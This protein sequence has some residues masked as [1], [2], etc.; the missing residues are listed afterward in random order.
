MVILPEVQEYT[1]NSGLDL[2]ET[3]MPDARID[4]LSISGTPE[5]W[6]SAIRRL[7][8]AGADTVVLAPLPDKGPD[9]LDVFANHFLG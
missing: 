7:V 1:D 8:S 9:E 4:Q 6:R 2:L 5:E 3:E